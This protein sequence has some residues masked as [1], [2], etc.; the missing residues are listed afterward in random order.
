MLIS[1]MASVGHLGF[2]YSLGHQIIQIKIISVMN[3][4][5]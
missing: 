2:G 1:K 4:P 5:Y 3:S